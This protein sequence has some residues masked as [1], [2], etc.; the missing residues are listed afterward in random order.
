MWVVLCGTSL[1]KARR[2]ALAGIDAVERAE[3]LTSP[4]ELVEG[5]AG[6]PL[7]EAADAFRLAREDLDHP[8]LL[9]L[10]VLPVVGRQVRSARALVGAADDIVDIGIRAVDEAQATL[11]LPRRTGPERLALLR[12]LGVAAARFDA[13]LGTVDLGPGRALV[14]PLGERRSELAERL[15]EVRDAMGTGATVATG[16][17]DLLAGPR[18]YLV[19]GANNAEMRAGSGMFLSL[20][21]LTFADGSMALGGFR[22]A[23]ELVLPAG[24]GPPIT[25]PDLAARWGWMNPNTEWRNL[26]ASPRFA[27]NAELAAQMWL[28]HQGQAVDGVLMVDPVALRGLLTSTGPVAVAGRAVSADNVL[29]LLLHDQYAGIDEGGESAQ[30]ARREMLGL[31]AATTLDAVQRQEGDVGA[32]ATAFGDMAAGRHLMAWSRDPAGQEVWEAAGVTGA[33][34]DRSLL[35]SVLNRGGN[36][37]DPF[38]DVDAGLDVEPAPGGGTT[39]ELRVTMR[40]TTP[41]GEGAYVA[42]G[43]HRSL[44]DV[45]PGV[46]HGLLSVNL[47]GSADDVTVDGG[48]P[49]AA[50]GPDGPTTVAAWPVRVERGATQTAV[51][52]FRL[53]TGMRDLTVEPSARVPAVAWSAEGQTWDSGPRR[54]LEW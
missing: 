22:P 12:R 2:D 42:G 29:A 9:P 37:L 30:A 6:E 10:R 38:L 53:P 47:P 46:Y 31:I 3:R 43:G 5:T 21:V 7:R 14:G 54:Q 51:V 44:P 28:A 19:V 34:A 41:E 45:G 15:D 24:T 23:A 40:N 50:A 25:D 32:L 52:R 49:L 35:V 13:E 11:A 4:S 27:P 48:P 17:A 33:L 36:K 39:V 18:T 1:A 20:G 8:A 16:L 26:A